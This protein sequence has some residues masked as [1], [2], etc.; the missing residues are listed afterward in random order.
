MR[1]V[2]VWIIRPSQFRTIGRFDCSK[3]ICDFDL[4]QMSRTKFP[5]SKVAVTINHDGEVD[6]NVPKVVW[7]KIDDSGTVVNINE[8]NAL[9]E[10]A[11]TPTVQWIQLL[12]HKRAGSGA[13]VRKERVREIRAAHGSNSA[14]SAKSRQV[15]RQRVRRMEKEQQRPSAWRGCT[16]AI[17]RPRE[18]KLARCEYHRKAR[19]AASVLEIDID[20]D[21][22][23]V[24]DGIQ[25]WAETVTE[26]CNVGV[27]ELT[28]RAEAGLR[29]AHGSM[30]G[31]SMADD[32]QRSMP[33]TTDTTARW[34]GSRAVCGRGRVDNCAWGTSQMTQ[35]A[36]EAVC[37]ASRAGG[38]DVG[39]GGL[40]N[41][42]EAGLRREHEG[43][44]AGQNAERS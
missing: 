36:Q 41:R 9:G 5:G 29:G 40:I 19:D 10:N 35:D 12:A 20:L 34:V 42:A 31:R 3:G 16:H 25:W 24:E 33:A 43:E 14:N 11:A 27:G 30:M 44:E 37:V 4:C 18:P 23:L 26:L 13:G 17:H 7:D 22:N 6:R 28:G 32:E 38:C 2:T 8:P 1:R 39:T 21:K 15:Q